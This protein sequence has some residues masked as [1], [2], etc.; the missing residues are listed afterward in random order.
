MDNRVDTLESIS[1]QVVNCLLCDLAKSRINAVPGNGDIKS[2]VV[3][4]GEA[5]GK[6]EDETGVPFV[7]SAGKILEKALREAGFDRKE[8][9]IT[10]VVKCRPPNNRIP[11]EFEIETCTSA[12]LKVELQV[13]SPKIVCILG[14]TA[15]KSL[16]GLGHMTLYRGKI[17]TRPPY[18]YFVTYHPAATI[19]NNKLKETFDSDIKR[20]YSLIKGENKTLN[21]FA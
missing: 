1:K 8:V 20:L 3:F 4:V 12:H 11:N 17:I 6:N 7:G 18:R 19:Y 15:L 9:Y 16:L 13:L 21:D 10:N 5:P 14:A 2:K